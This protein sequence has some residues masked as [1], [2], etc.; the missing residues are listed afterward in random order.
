MRIFQPSTQKEWYIMYKHRGVK[1]VGG[2]AYIRH[3]R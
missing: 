2:A 3:G 1:G